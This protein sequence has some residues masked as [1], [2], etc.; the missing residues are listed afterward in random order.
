M[1]AMHSLMSTKW[2]LPPHAMNSVLAWFSPHHAGTEMKMTK[3]EALQQSRK[4]STAS[5]ISNLNRVW[6]SKPSAITRSEPCE[7]VLASSVVQTTPLF[8]TTELSN[9]Y[10]LVKVSVRNFNI[11][12]QYRSSSERGGVCVWWGGSHFPCRPELSDQ[13]TDLLERW[14]IVQ[15]RL[16]LF[17]IQQP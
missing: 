14:W 5:C 6:Q 11:S 1:F 8:R 9:I 2:P 16:I 12:R 4:A 13:C 7:R 3:A 17:E 10:C 15:L